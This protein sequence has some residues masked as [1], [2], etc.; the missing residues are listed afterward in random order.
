MQKM[1][2]ATTT[3]TT[4]R[5]TTT[6]T[7]SRTTTTTTTTAAAAATT[8][9]NSRQQSDHQL[10]DGRTKHKFLRQSEPF[11]AKTD[12]FIF[13]GKQEEREKEEEKNWRK[14]RR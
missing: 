5:T 9:W 11:N 1:A 6:A 7:T 10:D 12:N 14:V 8:V 3:A 2:A 4:S 13:G